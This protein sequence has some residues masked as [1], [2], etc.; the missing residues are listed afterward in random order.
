MDDAPA[1]LL[2]MWFPTQQMDNPEAVIS[3]LVVENRIAFRD[4]GSLL[5]VSKQFHDAMERLMAGTSF[6]HDIAFCT[7]GVRTRSDAKVEDRFIGAIRRMLTFVD[8]EKED[9]E[10]ILELIVAGYNADRRGKQQRMI[11]WRASPKHHAWC[12]RILKRNIPEEMLIRRPDVRK[13][14]YTPPCTNSV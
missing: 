9:D 11:E 14:L 13:F 7:F 6:W 10:M 5:L 8:V 4:I 12:T 1:W 2:S 3:I